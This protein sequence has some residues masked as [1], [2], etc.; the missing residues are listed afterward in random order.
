MNVLA[1]K[2]IEKQNGFAS[3]EHLCPDMLKKDNQELLAQGESLILPFNFSN[4]LD[5][6]NVQAAKED[7]SVEDMKDPYDVLR[8]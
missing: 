7:F 2:Y 8:E 3:I 4:L 6:Y 5:Y 1:L